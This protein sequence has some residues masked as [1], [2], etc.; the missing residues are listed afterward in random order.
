MEEDAPGSL[1]VGM[2]GDLKKANEIALMAL[3]IS[4]RHFKSTDPRTRLFAL[5]GIATDHQNTGISIDYA[6]TTEEV[7]TMFAVQNL[8]TGDSLLCLSSAGLAH[9]SEPESRLPSWVPDV[10]G[11]HFQIDQGTESDKGRVSCSVLLG[12][13]KK[14]LQVQVVAPTL[15]KVAE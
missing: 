1:S 3:L 5:F 8:R 4:T 14:T 10:R 7:F 2:M 15:P 9:G 11:A 13:A 6:L 12:L